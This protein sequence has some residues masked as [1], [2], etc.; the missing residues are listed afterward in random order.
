MSQSAVGEVLVVEGPKGLARNQRVDRGSEPTIVQVLSASLTVSPA[1]AARLRRHQDP[2]RS[3]RRPS[4]GRAAA[5]PTE[6]F[7]RIS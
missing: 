7:P 2:G 3:R 1:P 5:A 4:P 6:A